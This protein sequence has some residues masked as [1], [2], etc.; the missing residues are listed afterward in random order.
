MSDLVLGATALP[1]GYGTVNPFVAVTGP[2]GAPAF[3]DFLTAVFAGRETRSARTPDADGL[4]I[5][6]EV[7]VGTSTIMLCDSKPG[8]AFTP[9]LLQVY[10]PGLDEPV[11]R[12]V[13]RG[14]EVVTEPTP[15][16]GDQRLARLRDPWHNLWW[17][18]EYG[19]QSTAPAEHPDEV[20]Q[21][22]PDPSA[23]AGYVKR[24][25]DGALRALTPP[26]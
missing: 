4:L 11:L 12:A 9:A 7:R 20:P 24:T 23:P 18:F 3:V 14:A 22:R 17:L 25:V 6:A 13:E 16:H 2:G 1:P 8:W 5:H 21:W 19:E 10:V 26:G 15:F